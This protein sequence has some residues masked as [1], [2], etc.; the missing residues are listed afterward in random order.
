M[1]YSI[2]YYRGNRVLEKADEVILKYYEKNPHIITFVQE[3]IPEFRRVVLDIT[4]LIDVEDNLDI[5][6][7]TKAILKISYEYQGN[8]VPILAEENIPYFFDKVV[9]NLDELNY[10]LRLCPSAIYVGN[11]LGFSIEKV[12]KICKNRKIEIRVYPNV[13][14]SMCP[15]DPENFKKFFIRP[16]DVN[17][18][19]Q[20]VDYFEFFGTIDRQPVLYEIYNDEKWFGDL[21]NLIIGLEK[22][23][24]SPQIVPYFGIRRLNCGKRC[25]YEECDFCDTIAG[26][27]D[28]L[29]EKGLSFIADDGKKFEPSEGTVSTSGERDTI[30]DEAIPKN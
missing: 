7:A 12:S 6:K 13:A 16:E 30:I 10:I 29:K 26:I 2:R 1:K 4:R 14:Q 23:I 8:I 27:A 21:D 11:E 9:S 3:S 22:T 18:Y 20:Y 5:L 17:L 24:Y 25:V 28:T 15:K 19:E